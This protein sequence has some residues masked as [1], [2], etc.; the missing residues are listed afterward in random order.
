MV[1]ATMCS[2]LTDSD[3]NLAALTDIAVSSLV[4][5]HIPLLGHLCGDLPDKVVWKMVYLSCHQVR[6]QDRCTMLS[7]VTDYIVHSPVRLE[8]SKSGTNPSD[9]IRV[10]AQCWQ[11][12]LPSGKRDLDVR[13]L[14][15]LTVTL[16]RCVSQLRRYHLHDPFI[17]VLKQAMQL[18]KQARVDLSTM[19][20]PTIHEPNFPRIAEISHNKM[21]R[22]RSYANLAPTAAS[23][24]TSPSPAH[25]KPPSQ[26]R[27]VYQPSLIQQK[28]S[29]PLR[30]LHTVRPQP[31]RSIPV[32]QKPC[33]SG[34]VNRPVR[35]NPSSSMS[36]SSPVIRITHVMARKVP[37]A[38]AQRN[39]HAAVLKLV[40]APH[41][42]SAS[43]RKN[44]S[45]LAQ[46]NPS[47]QVRNMSS[48]NPR[49]QAPPFPGYTPVM[50]PTSSP[51]SVQA[52]Q[53]PPFRTY[54]STI[55][56][57]RPFST[58]RQIPSTHTQP[59]S[60]TPVRVYSSTLARQ[61]PVATATK[62][63]S[64]PPHRQSTTSNR[65]LS[66]W[67]SAPSPVRR[68]TSVIRATTGCTLQQRQRPYTPTHHQPTSS[69][70]TQPAT[71]PQSIPSDS[72][73]AT[74]TRN[75]GTLPQSANRLT[76]KQRF[77]IHAELKRLHLVST[78]P[79]MPLHTSRMSL[80]PSKRSSASVAASEVSAHHP[81]KEILV[82]VRQSVYKQKQGS[83][84]HPADRAVTKE[85]F[86]N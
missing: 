29:T 63:S 52:P 25:Q 44:P 17:V 11:N 30:L 41:T 16:A 51:T 20:F 45:T 53:I 40:P 49:V 36:S 68:D 15:K 62:Q 26:V 1:D 48:Q 32:P 9:I 60:S 72:S 54:A 7:V 14:H 75:L 77:L 12:T 46:Q 50:V 19:S 27:P 78:S 86:F 61:N 82:E 76:S 31:P 65:Y 38:P 22:F 39:T 84:L 21:R 4:N 66:S 23:L 10:L 59:I 3:A 83:T 35:T 5:T 34:N 74:Q 37:L 57:P 58:A 56:P 81:A 64:S 80:T 8:T 47:S 69:T 24:L 43:T 85:L 70:K 33:V 73:P 42:R 6:A 28:V 13:S 18:K 71:V 67:H 2:L 55:S 79:A